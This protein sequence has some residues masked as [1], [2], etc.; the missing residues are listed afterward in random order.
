MS[1]QTQFSLEHPLS[2]TDT[3][4]EKKR[5]KTCGKPEKKQKSYSIFNMDE[6]VVKSNALFYLFIV[7]SIFV[8]TT[9]SCHGASLIC[10]Y[11]CNFI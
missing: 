7:V 10:K 3:Q 6:I 4:R 5:T 9:E 1:V 8:G 11:E 2:E